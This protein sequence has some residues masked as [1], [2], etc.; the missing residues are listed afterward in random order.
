MTDT[1]LC[2]LGAAEAISLF[3]RKALSP[4]ELMEAVIAR[5]EAVGLDAVVVATQDTVGRVTDALGD[6]SVSYDVTK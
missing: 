3:K 2:Y 6:T 1:D 4:V 5:A